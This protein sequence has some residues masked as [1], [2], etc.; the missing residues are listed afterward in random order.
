MPEFSEGPGSPYPYTVAKVRKVWVFAIERDYRLA[1]RIN[2][3]EFDEEAECEMLLHN[4][5]LA[6]RLGKTEEAI[7]FTWEKFM[8]HFIKTWGLT[9]TQQQL[10]ICRVAH[11]IWSM[12]IDQYPSCT[13]F[14]AET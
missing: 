11:I 3:G 13:D 10:P 1:Q 14:S 5:R 12:R 9:A 2:R 8:P 6:D 4:I 7:Q